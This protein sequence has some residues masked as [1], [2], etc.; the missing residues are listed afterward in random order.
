MVY[1]RRSSLTFKATEEVGASSCWRE[2]LLS[3]EV[4]I[5]QMIDSFIQEAVRLA[6]DGT[7]ADIITDIL[8]TRSRSV[9]LLRTRSMLIMEGLRAIRAGHNP[10]V[11]RHKLAA[12][13]QS[14]LAGFGDGLR[15]G[16][17]VP[18]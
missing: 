16:G 9:L 3:F 10:V 7:E 12:T 18:D 8:E 17:G 2:G 13:Y 6:V 11:V 4:L 1:R 14:D 5:L 15:S